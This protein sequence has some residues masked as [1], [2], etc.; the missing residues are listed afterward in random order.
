MADQTLKKDA[1]KAPMDLLPT[2]ALREVA[3]VLGFGAKKYS[4]GGWLGG[5]AW[6]RLYGAAMRH[7]SS[8]ME[9][10]D[11]DNETGL[12]HLA[13]ASCCCLFLLTYELLGLGTDDRLFAD[14]MP[15][16]PSAVLAAEQAKKRNG[17][18]GS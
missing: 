7:L 3:K 11:T 14:G 9:G 16:K 4:R 12:S 5:M 8:H 18:A 10:Q 2:P 13:H 1:G 17:C 6:S 15:K